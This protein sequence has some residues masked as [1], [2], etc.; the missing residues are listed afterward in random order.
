MW[1]YI[2]KLRCES[3][4]EKHLNDCAESWSKRHS[5]SPSPQTESDTN[6]NNNSNGVKQKSTRWARVEHRR[7]K[8]GEF[9]AKIELSS[10]AQPS[11]VARHFFSGP[12]D[13]S[14]KVISSHSPSLIP[15]SF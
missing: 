3:L 15:P 4:D 2:F 7:V 8:E 5:A 12:P 13:K 6:N 14:P 10:P 1:K 11:E 9:E